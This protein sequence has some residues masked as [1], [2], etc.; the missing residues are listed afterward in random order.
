MAFNVVPISEIHTFPIQLISYR[1]QEITGRR[2]VWLQ[3][4]PSIIKSCE[5]VELSWK[6]KGEH[7]NE[8]DD[9][10]LHN[11]VRKESNLKEVDN[12]PFWFVSHKL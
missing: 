3:V 4:A 11:F 6:L 9:I 2:L 7:S 12:Y 10:H 8:R 5:I 1:F